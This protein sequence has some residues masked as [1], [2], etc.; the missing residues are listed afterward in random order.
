MDEAK[1]AACRAQ[2]KLL[3]GPPVASMTTKSTACPARLASSVSKPPSSLAK[4]L[5]LPLTPGSS[6]EGQLGKANADNGTTCACGH[7][8][9]S[10]GQADDHRQ[11]PRRGWREF[12]SRSPAMIPD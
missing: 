6:V 12:G 8:L 11:W 5:M 9:G 10:T 4:V 7:Q 3:P 1:P 2:A